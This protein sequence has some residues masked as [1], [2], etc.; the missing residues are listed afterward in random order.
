M[1]ADQ[2]NCYSL[3]SNTVKFLNFRMPE[4]FGVVF[5]KFKQIGQK[6]RV[7]YQNDPSGIAN[8][9]D[10]DQT[11]PLSFCFHF[12]DSTIPLLFAHADLSENLGSLR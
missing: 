10:P 5:L 1:Q 12:T 4:N 3:P 2:H 8:S 7:V 11:A 9:E 6:L